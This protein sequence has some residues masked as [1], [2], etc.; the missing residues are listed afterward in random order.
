VDQRFE[1]RQAHLVA[2]ALDDLGRIV[3]VALLELVHRTVVEPAAIPVFDLL[4]HRLVVARVADRRER[5]QRIHDAED[6]HRADVLADELG[7]LALDGERRAAADVVV[8]VEDHEQPDV[9]AAELG[10]LVPGRADLPGQLTLERVA[11]DLDV[12]EALDLLE[13]VVL[14]DLEV[15][16]GQVLDGVALVVGDQRVDADEVDAGAEGGRLR[17]RGLLRPGGRPGAGGVPARAWRWRR[18]RRRA[19]VWA[20]G[21]AVPG[22]ERRPD[23]ARIGIT[24][25]PMSAAVRRR[26]RSEPQDMDFSPG[27][28]AG[29]GHNTAKAMPEPV[30]AAAAAP[31]PLSTL[32]EDER[33]FRDSVRDFAADRVAPLVRAMDEQQ[34]LDPGLLRSLFALGAMGI[35]VPEAHGGAGG[36]FFHATLAIEELSRVDPAVGVVVDVHNTLVVNALLR[37][38][39]PAQ[40]ADVLPRLASAALGAYA[41]SEHEAGSDAFALAT[42]AER[43]GD[44][45]RI[46]GRKVWITNGAEADVFI[47]FA[48]I[49]ARPAT[50][51]SPPSWSSAARPAS[52]SAARKRSSASAP[53]APA[54]CSSTAAAS[55][56]RPCSASR[57]AATRSPSRR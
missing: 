22:P 38:G 42:R 11:L 46:H 10:L 4:D 7:E 18:G 52:P 14:V 43:D 39:T 47:V 45:Y 12:A 48:T 6:V 21:P 33:L 25:A 20:G 30:D 55:T 57:G 24:D 34:A 54:S 29:F 26:A 3:G 27:V 56:P 49:D 40:Q 41:L 44:G 19:G 28:G 5:R 50:A 36:T 9:V 17:G 8:V 1:G 53:A 51:A 31:S 35:E 13:L 32:T 23:C 37:W 16:L 2:D 15:V